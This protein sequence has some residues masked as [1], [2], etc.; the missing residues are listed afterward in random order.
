MSSISCTAIHNCSQINEDLQFR[1]RRCAAVTSRAAALPR[2]QR[3]L[4]NQ[5]NK[6][7][8]E[9]GRELEATNGAQHFFGHRDFRDLEPQAS[10]HL[11]DHRHWWNY[12]QLRSRWLYD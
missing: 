6:W 7:R 4:E 5:P 12:F 10:W 2:R 3:H 8:L 9:H 11:R 1:Y